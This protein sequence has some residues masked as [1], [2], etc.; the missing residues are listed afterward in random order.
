MKKLMLIVF[1]VF[2]FINNYSFGQGVAIVCFKD[3]FCMEITRIQLTDGSWINACCTDLPPAHSCSDDCIPPNL[4]LTVPFEGFNQNP[5]HFQLSSHNVWILDE[6]EELSQ[7]SYDSQSD[8]Y[9][10]LNNISNFSF[11]DDSD[12]IEFVTVNLFDSLTAII[13]KSQVQLRKKNKEISSDASNFFENAD[14]ILKNKY[15]LSLYPNPVHFGEEI[16]FQAPGK[17][18]DIEFINLS[19]STSSEKILKPKF[20]E[21]SNKIYKIH[22]VVPLFKGVFFVKITLHN[23]VRMTGKLII[24]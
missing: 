2:I 19:S 8:E 11:I 5:A 18:K 20:L 3:G 10:Y 7:D 24:I 13:G 12:S 14:E 15:S 21:S 9:I 6:D 1:A 22:I 16:T 23:G 17:V 4:A